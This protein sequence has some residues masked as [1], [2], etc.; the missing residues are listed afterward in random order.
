[1]VYRLFASGKKTHIVKS[2]E[3]EFEY[4]TVESEELESALGDGWFGSPLEALE[5]EETSTK[6]AGK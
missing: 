2:H 1:M 5:S 4:K 6:K 3:R